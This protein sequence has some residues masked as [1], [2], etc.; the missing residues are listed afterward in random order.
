MEDKIKQDGEKF[1]KRF[2][3]LKEQAERRFKAARAGDLLSPRVKQLIKES[4]ERRD[5]I[6]DLLTRSFEWAGRLAGLPEEEIGAELEKALEPKEGI[7][8]LSIGSLHRL[9]QLDSYIRHS[10]VEICFYNLKLFFQALPEKYG[11][12]G[13][14]DKVKENV[15]Q[16][17]LV[18]SELETF[19]N[20][21]IEKKLKIKFIFPDEYNQVMKE[22]GALEKL[23]EEGISTFDN[24]AHR[25]D[26]SKVVPQTVD[27]VMELLSEAKEKIESRKAN[28]VELMEKVVSLHDEQCKQNG[29]SLNLQ[30]NIP[31]KLMLFGNAQELTNAFSE[32]IANARKHAFNG[33]PDEREKRIVI[34]LDYEDDSQQNLRVRISDNGVGIPEEQLSKIEYRGV[35]TKGSGE[36]IPVIKRIIENR[37]LGSVHFNSQPGQGTTAEVLLP[38]KLSFKEEE[39]G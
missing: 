10:L 37:Y 30:R 22:M 8:L 24:T 9:E 16:I 28:I 3:L 19:F 11:K 2:H 29:I 25:E 12:P 31:E 4:D 39:D 38:I 17:P 26:L 18:K 36:G 1:E 20:G 34:Y 14:I 33:N 5:R 7:D 32:L 35:S 15:R 27:R 13:F 6:Q 21:E 23:S